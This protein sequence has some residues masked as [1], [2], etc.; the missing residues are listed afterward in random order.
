MRRFCCAFCTCESTSLTMTLNYARIIDP[1]LCILQAEYSISHL[2][3]DF[4]EETNILCKLIIYSLYHRGS[5]W[6]LSA[7]VHFLFMWTH[8][9]AKSIQIIL[10]FLSMKIIKV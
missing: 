5:E 8:E 7:F 9:G 4:L 6:E 1:T 3:V 10:F 2:C